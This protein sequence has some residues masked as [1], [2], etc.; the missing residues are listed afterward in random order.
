MKA[1]GMG[2][3]GLVAMNTDM[4]IKPSSVQTH[5]NMILQ[6][7]THARQGDE[8]NKSGGLIKNLV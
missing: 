2:I 1:L 3:A 4:G 7:N 8:Y 5:H 6:T